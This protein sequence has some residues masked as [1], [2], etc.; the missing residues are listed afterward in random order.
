[1]KFADKNSLRIPLVCIALCSLAGLLSGFH[2]F[3]DLFNH[4]RPQAIVATA[5]LLIPI[6]LLRSKPL[7][8]LA[9]GIIILNAGLMGARLYSFSQNSADNAQ[10]QQTQ[11][12]SILLANIHTFNT[13]YSRF[14]EQVEK[15][16]ADI[17]AVLE[18]N[19]P[20]IKKLEV[21][22]AVYPHKYKQPADDNFGFAI[23]SKIPFKGKTTEI[24]ELYQLPVFTGDF[25]SFTL[26]ALHPIPPLSQSDAQENALYITK[27]VYSDNR[28]NQPLVIVGDFNAT[29]WSDNIKP[30]IENKL[31]PANFWGLAWTWP[32]GFFPLAIQL[33]HVFVRNATVRE[34]DTLE[35]IGSDH[36]PVKVVIEIPQD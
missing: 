5:L 20:W 27:A 18:V 7:I 29:L 36:Y 10:H 25:G 31:A 35:D 33:D 16:D 21:I 13:E 19:Q 30:L 26:K 6:A 32:A 22:E 2:W 24:G 12:V 9:L 15:E 8:L 4:F 34:F 14:I 28:N 17:V 3:F 1:M 23:Y 11:G